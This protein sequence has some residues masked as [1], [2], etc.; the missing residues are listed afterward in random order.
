[1]ESPEQR[2]TCYTLPVTCHLRNTRSNSFGPGTSVHLNLDSGVFP[3]P[4]FVV[5]S[6]LLGRDTISLLTFPKRTPTYP[7]LPTL[8]PSTST[9]QSY[10]LYSVPSARITAFGLIH[11]A[12]YP[13]CT[14]CGHGSILRTLIPYR[15][16]SIATNMD[17]L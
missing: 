2:H 15:P 9:E 16:R 1:M 3:V 14:A 17:H 11:G 10:R 13:P 4:V 5:S 6:L 8:I 12:I 7:F